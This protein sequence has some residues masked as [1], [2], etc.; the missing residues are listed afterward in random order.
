MKIEENIIRILK[1]RKISLTS[2]SKETNIE[3]MKLYDSLMNNARGR[4]LRADEFMVICE[5]LGKK[6][7]ELYKN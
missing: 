6:A 5:V 2:L 1:E 4:K 3:Y 7:E